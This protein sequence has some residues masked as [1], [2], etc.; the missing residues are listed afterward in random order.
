MTFMYPSLP[1]WGRSSSKIKKYS[2]LH[3]KC[4]S[5]PNILKLKMTS[6]LVKKK[7]KQLSET[8]QNIHA[9]LNKEGRK[10]R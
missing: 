7:K 10:K 1:V 9:D 4:H 2:A 3:S 5:K 6:I 8:R